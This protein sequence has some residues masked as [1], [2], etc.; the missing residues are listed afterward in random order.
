MGGG[1][2]RVTPSERF[3]VKQRQHRSW[4]RKH[5]GSLCLSTAVTL[6]MGGGAFALIGS[7]SAEAM[8][9]ASAT[10]VDVFWTP[11][12]SATDVTTVDQVMEVERKIAN[13]YWSMQVG[14]AP[15]ANAKSNIA[16]MGLQTNSTRPDGTTGEMGI[17]SVWDA[18]KSRNRDGQCVVFGG[19]GD[20]LSCRAALPFST[21]TQ[22][23]Y[24]VQ[25]LEADSTGQWWGGW[26]R[27]MSTGDETYLGDL[28]NKNTFMTSSVINFSEYWGASVPCERL[29]SS[30]V[31]WTQPA[32]K[33]DTADST[34][35]YHTAYGSM[36]HGECTKAAVVPVNLN[37]TKGV[38]VV[39]GAD[40]SVATPP[41][42]AAA[43]ST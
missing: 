5:A 18:D 9:D 41:T 36:Q 8:S 22:Y 29:A 27:N 23:R 11:D 26:I 38:R 32:A 10:H 13:G 12:T 37:W 17:F 42:S 39:A 28:H 14:F 31:L 19:E 6:A 35:A 25:R 2:S 4:V 24:R 7:A 34:Y 21:G 33:T 30:Q 3:L 40:T 16:Y 43:P 15:T 1:R 20:G